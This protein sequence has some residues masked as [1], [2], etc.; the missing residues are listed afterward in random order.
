MKCSF[1]FALAMAVASVGCGDG[2]VSTALD[3]SVAV[4]SG[5][6]ERD[7]GPFMFR[8][9]SGATCA[10]TGENCLSNPCCGT[11]M[12]IVPVNGG[13]PTCQGFISDGG[14][15]PDATT[16]V[17]A[18][19]PDAT[20]EMDA[21]VDAAVPTE[22]DIRLVVLLGE[23]DPI[24]LECDDDDTDEGVATPPGT[25]EIGS[26]TSGERTCDLNVNDLFL[27]E[28]NI[29]VSVSTTSGAF[30]LAH[31]GRTGYA[32]IEE[33]LTA[34]P[35]HFYAHFVNFYGS[36]DEVTF[37]DSSLDPRDG[38][39]IGRTEFGDYTTGGF[40]LVTTDR[41]ID[42]HFGADVDD[43]GTP[44]VWFKLPKETTLESE[45]N[46]VVNFFFFDDGDG[47][48]ASRMYVQLSSGEFL[49]L[50][51]IFEETVS[52]RLAS[53]GGGGLVSEFG[54]QAVRL[55]CP[56]PDGNASIIRVAPNTNFVP[57]DFAT[58]YAWPLVCE[59]Y[60]TDSGDLLSE[61][62]FGAAAAFGGVS[63]ALRGDAEPV[64][65]ELAPTIPETTSVRFVNLSTSE[66]FGTTIDQIALDAPLDARYEGT[67]SAEEDTALSFETLTAG[68]ELRIRWTSN[69]RGH[70]DV[71]GLFSN[72]GEYIVYILLNNDDE[73]GIVIQPPPGSGE[74]FT[75]VAPS[76]FGPPP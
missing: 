5:S 1:G 8:D 43:D 59:V 58:V 2:H 46:P 20:V 9:G 27:L 22:S 71:T 37:Y 13:S 76:F 73:Y 23:G 40:Q 31:T 67:L 66:F 54:D 50:D 48:S 39:S 49:T 11:L 12:C 60:N 7:M 36:A 10:E 33:E 4:D 62:P 21:T 18:A 6:V 74:L 65:F 41:E 68:P 57:T 26:I 28:E 70:Y 56:G 51:P 16:P 25:S 72:E 15:S 64:G 63:L 30:T 61:F 69:Q 42:W 19:A 44:D 29:P 55:D 53:L 35:G 32:L 3:G 24:S 52:F 17:D 34:E 38:V 45:A 75:E 47:L 14:T